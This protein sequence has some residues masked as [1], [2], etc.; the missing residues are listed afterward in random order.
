M[1]GI[2]HAPSRDAKILA[3]EIG[4]G[5]STAEQYSCHSSG[6]YPH[7]RINHKITCIGEGKYQTLREFYRELTWVSGLLWMISLDVRENPHIPRVFSEWVA[8]ILPPLRSLIGL[9]PWIFLGNA[10]S[11]QIEGVGVTLRVPKN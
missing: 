9:L 3:H 6:T 7:E 8:R 11:I 2:N 4:P 5:N 1:S 10:N